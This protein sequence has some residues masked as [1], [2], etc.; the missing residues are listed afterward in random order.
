MS[1][2]GNWTLHY[3]WGCSG[4]YG[5]TSLTFNANGTFKDGQG[6]S[7]QWASLVGQVQFVY[8]PTP[9]A[10]YSGNVSG[11][12]MS[13]MMTNFHLGEQGCWYAIMTKIPE[14]HATAK[15][16]EHAEQLDAAGE[17]KK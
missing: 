7:G 9:S 1:L 13:G 3:S 11:G 12:T 6:H 4:S 15:K 14:A 5:N 16:V 10:V 17:K 8:E 2:A